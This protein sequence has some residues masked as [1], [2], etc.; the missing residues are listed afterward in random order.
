MK[1]N[2][3]DHLPGIWNKLHVIGLR[4]RQF[5]IEIFLKLKTVCKYDGDA[6]NI[7]CVH[8]TTQ[9]FFE[10]NYKVI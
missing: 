8:K 9:F 3:D 6:E 4:K 7:Q 2:L 10:Q 5:D 1:F